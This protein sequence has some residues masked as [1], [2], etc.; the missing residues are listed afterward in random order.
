MWQILLTINSVLLSLSTVYLIY[1]VGAALI[2]GHWKALLISFLITAF[3]VFIE[4]TIA[5]IIQS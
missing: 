4:L 5:A 2:L 3:L 1:S